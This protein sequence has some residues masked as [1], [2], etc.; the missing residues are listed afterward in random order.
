MLTGTLYPFFKWGHKGVKGEN[1]REGLENCSKLLTGRTRK[2]TRKHLF[3]LTARVT[4]YVKD[5][6]SKDKIV[7][8]GV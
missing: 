1:R 7:P 4:S 6:P 5:R 3:M 8:S 2:Q